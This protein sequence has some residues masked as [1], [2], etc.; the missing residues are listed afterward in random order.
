MGGAGREGRL[1]VHLR[2]ARAGRRKVYTGATVRSMER[3]G[4]RDLRIHTANAV[5]RA[6]AGERII[7][8]VDG[9]PAAQLGPLGFEPGHSTLDDLLSAGLV[10]PPRARTPPSAAHPARGGRRSSDEV[11]NEHRNR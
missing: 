4:I 8:T 7:V 3:I 9:V 11:L 6:R 2:S 5:R 1:T 10:R